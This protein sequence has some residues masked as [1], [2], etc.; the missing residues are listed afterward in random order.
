MSDCLMRM[1]G[2]GR[3]GSSRRIAPGFITVRS[4]ACC[5]TI[6]LGEELEAGRDRAGIPVI[7]ARDDVPESRL[8][9]LTHSHAAG[10]GAEQRGRVELHECPALAPPLYG[11]RRATA[12]ALGVRDDRDEPSVPDASKGVAHRAKGDEP[13]ELDQDVPGAAERDPADLSGL[14][15]QR[16]VEHHLGAA[17][18]TRELRRGGLE[19][20]EGPLVLG[21]WAGFHLIGTQVGRE[22]DVGDTRPWPSR[23]A[24]RS[25]ARSSGTRRPHRE[26][27]GNEVDHGRGEP[28]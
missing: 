23:A 14:L 3:T 25:I 5:E 18:E 28:A 9:K 4:S 24:H 13:G 15:P 19:L 17:M 22:A 11:A 2:T 20:L 21:R 16:T 10:G 1:G 7:V 6:L 8:Q 27:D 12:V 26:G